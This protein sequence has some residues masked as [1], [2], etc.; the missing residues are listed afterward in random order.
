MEKTLKLFASMISKEYDTQSLETLSSLYKISESPVIFATAFSRVY[1]ICLNLRNKFY[2]LDKDNLASCSCYILHKC[3][4]SYVEDSNASFNT[5][6]GRCLHNE[7]VNE[8]HKFSSAQKGV[9]FSIDQNF[10]SDNVSDINTLICDTSVFY[11]ND[12]WEDA[13]IRCLICQDKSLTD[14]ERNLCL[15]LINTNYNQGEVSRILGISRQY[16][17][18]LKHSIAQKL[19]FLAKCEKI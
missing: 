2:F 12:L 19:Q 6:F 15:L 16:Y 1:P 17:Y 5:F 4:L 11:S 10:T 18:N 9:S 7:F 14:K 13:D 8:Y 3:L